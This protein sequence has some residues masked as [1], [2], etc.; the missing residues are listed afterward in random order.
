MTVWYAGWND[1]SCHPAC[2][3]VIQS[4]KHVEIDNILRIN[5]LKINCAS[6]W[7]YLQDEWRVF[8]YFYY[9]CVHFAVKTY[10]LKVI[11][12]VLVFQGLLNY[13]RVIWT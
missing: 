6:S 5:I 8:S 4:P 12:S 3:T 7:L 2:Q 13:S 9:E 11:K 1:I 10:L